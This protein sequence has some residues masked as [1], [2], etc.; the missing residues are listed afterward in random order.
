M[1]GIDI[2]ALTIEYRV[3]LHHDQGHVNVRI[4]GHQDAGSAVRA[5]LTSERAPVRSVVWVKRRP[6]CDQCDQ[7]ATRYVTDS[8][9]ETPLCM[10]CALDHYDTRTGIREH[11]GELGI[12][13]FERVGE[14][15]WKEAPAV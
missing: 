9:E 12:T 3:R 13:R 7:P 5:V 4:Y 10:E 15:E 2:A 1:N 11:T 8:S 6:T 14:S